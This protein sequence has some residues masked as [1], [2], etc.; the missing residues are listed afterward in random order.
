MRR[1]LEKPRSDSSMKKVV[2]FVEKLGHAEQD[3]RETRAKNLETDMRW[4]VSSQWVAYLGILLWLGFAPSTVCA[5]LDEAASTK[6]AGEERSKRDDIKR[7]FALMGME[8]S[9]KSLMPRV[10]DQLRPAMPQVSDELWHEFEKQFSAAELVEV[11]VPIYDKHFSHEEIKALLQFYDKPLGRKMITT[12]PLVSLELMGAAN[13]WGKEL[14]ARIAKQLSAQASNS[15]VPATERKP[16]QGKGASVGRQQTLT[17]QEKRLLIKS[18][19]L[20][21]DEWTVSDDEPYRPVPKELG[22][23]ET[24][25][26][27]GKQAEVGA[28]I[29][30]SIVPPPGAGYVIEV[31]DGVGFPTTYYSKEEPKP[32]GSGF[33][34]LIFP[35]EIEITISGGVTIFKI[36]KKD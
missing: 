17:E 6:S 23:S 27:L 18:R 3:P 29:P 32:Y 9:L 25:V 10:I 1:P 19:G 11:C 33:K 12:A 2:D 20:D 8:N 14:A 15:T 30:G 22:G 34:F 7:L 5:E 35:R 26:A 36:P 21:P 13:R 4:G 24:Q 31:T 28:S 16:G